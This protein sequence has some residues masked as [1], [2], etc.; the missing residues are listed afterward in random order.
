MVLAYSLRPIFAV[1]H[2]ESGLAVVRP[3]VVTPCI[4]VCSTALGDE[5]CRGCKRYS[6]EVIDWNSYSDAQKQIIDERLDGFLV[7]VMENK[8][9]INDAKL[10][11]WQLQTQRIRYPA[12]K[13]PYIWLFQLLRAG[14]GQINDCGQFGFS[15]DAEYRSEPLMALR[16]MIDR[17]HYLLSEAYYQ[18]YI[19]R[20]L[21]REL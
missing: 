2:W 20:Y 9:R 18:R 21:H 5:V 15:V 6:H 11:E 14:A 1:F 17:E 7:Q 13:S 8:L 19:G 12:H 16:D 3:R 4:G 10:L